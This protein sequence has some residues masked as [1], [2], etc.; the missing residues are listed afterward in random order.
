MEPSLRAYGEMVDVLW[1]RGEKSAALRLEELWNELQARR[2]FTLLCAYA[3]GKFY[4]EPADDPQLCAPRTRTSSGCTRMGRQAPRPAA[5]ACHR[6]THRSL[7]ERFSIARRWSSR[8]GSRYASFVQR[9]SSCARVRS[10]SGTS[11]RTGPSPFIVS[12]PMVRSFGR[13]TRS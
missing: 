11:S 6:N 4:K 9:R 13:I 10:S 8:S 3:M 12:A 5:R 1:R 2:S 7:H